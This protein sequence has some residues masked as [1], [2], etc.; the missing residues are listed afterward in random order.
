[1]SLSSFYNEYLIPRLQHQSTT[2]AFEPICPNITKDECQRQRASS[3][4]SDSYVSFCE[5]VGLFQRLGNIPH[6]FSRCIFDP[7]S[8]LTQMCHWDIVRTSIRVTLNPPM[9]CHRPFLHNLPHHEHPIH[10]LY[11]LDS[12]QE[13]EAK[14]KHL[15]GTFISK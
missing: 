15:A 9:P 1:M 12:V 2:G 5:K 4:P 6:P 13:D 7:S 14:R 10:S 11:R 8:D 3:S